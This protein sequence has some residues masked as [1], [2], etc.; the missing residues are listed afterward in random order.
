MIK[1]VAMDTAL[2]MLG[3]E[4]LING[5]RKFAII[6]EYPIEIDAYGNKVISQDPTM[7]LRLSDAL[8]LSEGDEVDMGTRRFEIQSIKRDRTR[9]YATCALKTRRN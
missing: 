7:T 5:L 9:G 8:T 1:S 4:V 6:E 3:E 2:S